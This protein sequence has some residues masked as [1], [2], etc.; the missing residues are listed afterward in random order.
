MA[1]KN[2]V[3]MERTGVCGHGW[4]AR[5]GGETQSEGTPK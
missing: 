3:V 2:D 5:A 1:A 4:C